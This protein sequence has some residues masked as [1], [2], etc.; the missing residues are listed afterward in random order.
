MIVKFIGNVVLRTEFHGRFPGVYLEHELFKDK[1]NES[2]QY[3]KVQSM[4]PFHI[5]GFS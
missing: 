3:S 2:V 4:E 1:R 5:I